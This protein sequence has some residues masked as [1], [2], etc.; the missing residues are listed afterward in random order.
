[1]GW[2]ADFYSA[3]K[4]FINDR[5]AAGAVEVVDVDDRAYTFEN[6]LGYADLDYTVDISY[7]DTEGRLRLFTYNGGFSSLIGDLTDGELRK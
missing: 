3:V 2:K 6:S 7:K 4:E 1:M 5:Y